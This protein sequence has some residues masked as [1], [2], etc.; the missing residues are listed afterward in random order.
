V[1]NYYDE[2]VAQ[3]PDKM[4]ILKEMR[5][6]PIYEKLLE[7]AEIDPQSTVLIIG[8]STGSL[9]IFLAHLA[10]K[11]IGIDL[12]RESL[13]FAE[14]RTKQLNI[15]NIEYKKGDAEKLPIEDNSIYV[16]LT[17]CVINLVPTKQK[18]FNE[19]FRVLKTDGFL[20]M[21]DPVRKKP[22][23]ET[24]E[25]LLATCIAGTVAKESYRQMLMKAGF[26]NVEIMD[27]TD[28]A[29]KVFTGHEEKFQKYGL[30]YVIMK[31]NKLAKFTDSHDEVRE[32]VR[33]TY[34]KIAQGTPRCG[35][36]CG[37]PSD[38]AD[39]TQKIGYNEGELSSVL[40]GANLGLGCG[41]PVALASLKEGEI[42][43]DLGSGGGL[44][45]FLAA[46]KVGEKGRVIG[47]DMTPE[48]VGKA[49]ENARKSKHRNVEF[50]LG[51]IENLPVADNSVDVVISNCVIN[52]SP[53]KDRVFKEAYR[54]LRKDG[55]LIL[56]DIVLENPL[57]DEIKQDMD[58]YVRCIARAS[59]KQDYL[60]SIKNA[61]FREVKIVEISDIPSRGNDI[62][63]SRHGLILLEKFHGNVQKVIEIR[64][65]I[66]SAIISAIK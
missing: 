21:A 58:A 22:P 49:R 51:E 33:E 25:E 65:S 8:S 57:P 13:K 47:V 55:R 40:E 54:V 31:A 42:V 36:S 24:S 37:T 15:T 1:E 32:K 10:K 38:I 16:V 41:N 59:L 6:K 39:Y 23:E 35:S 48:M 53:D 26:E 29:K 44:D 63:E 45:C 43:L 28:V 46:N 56:S 64:K 50:R 20:V 4:L 66:K 62:K 9:P 14:R 27:I 30:E 52:L 17:D 11:V 18:V 2:R 60:N 12:S 19:I 5:M 7:F 61:G 34:S 3:F